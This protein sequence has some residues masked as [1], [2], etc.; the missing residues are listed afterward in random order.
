MI[1]FNKLIRVDLFLLIAVLLLFVFRTD[2]WRSVLEGAIAV[3]LLIS[4]LN[5]IEHY[6]RTKKWY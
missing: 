6:R 2:K 1:L 5:H 3:M 4:I